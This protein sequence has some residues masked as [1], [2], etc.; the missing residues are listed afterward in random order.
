MLGFPWTLT[1]KHNAVD[2]TYSFLF[3]NQ[4]HESDFAVYFLLTTRKKKHA[5]QYVLSLNM[6]VD[7]SYGLQTF[8]E[9]SRK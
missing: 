4:S 1:L 2:S 5:V 9:A 7:C 6:L 8:G 3:V